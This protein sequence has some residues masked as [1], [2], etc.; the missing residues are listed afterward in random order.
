MGEETV[1]EDVIEIHNPNQENLQEYLDRNLEQAKEH[2]KQQYEKVAEET[3]KEGA[4]VLKYLE[5][6]GVDLAEVSKMSLNEIKSLTIDLAFE[7][8]KR[9]GSKEEE[10]LNK[11]PVEGTLFGYL[12]KFVK[13]RLLM[14][15]MGFFRRR[16]AAI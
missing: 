11:I 12:P 15:F 2:I 1:D 5:D 4:E 6:S 3:K 8:G 13:K 14:Q 10:E 9:G 16:C 7:A